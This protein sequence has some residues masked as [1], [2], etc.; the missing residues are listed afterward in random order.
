MWLFGESIFNYQFWR[1]LRKWINYFRKLRDGIRHN[2]RSYFGQTKFQIEKIDLLNNR[3]IDPSINSTVQNKKM[4]SGN[5]EVR[6]MFIYMLKIHFSRDSCAHLH[7]LFRTVDWRQCIVRNN[8]KNGIQIRIRTFARNII[9]DN[10]VQCACIF[11]YDYVKRDICLNAGEYR[12]QSYETHSFVKTCAEKSI[13]P[14]GKR[15]TDSHLPHCKRVRYSFDS[16]CSIT[17][18]FF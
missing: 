8:C 5:R 3:D 9:I 6:Q 2:T 16:M 13:K 4:L 7:S 15:F 17:I 1:R 18:G 12:R 14:Y 11:E 10:I